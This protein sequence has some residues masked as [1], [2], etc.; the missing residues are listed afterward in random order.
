MSLHHMLRAAAQQQ[1][2]GPSDPNFKNVSLLLTGDGTNG[3]QNN[4][5]LDS[6]SNNFTITRNGNTTQGTFSPYGSLWSNYFD[7]SGDYLSRA[8]ASTTDGMYLQGT[9]YTIEA[10]IYMTSTNGLQIIYD[11]SGTNTAYFAT[12]S[13]YVD[14]GVL[15]YNVRPNTGSGFPVT[16]IVGS[17]I[18]SNTWNH[19]AFSVS[20]GSGKL[21]LNG[22]QTGSTT[23]IP[24][25]AFTPVGAAIG[26]FGNGYATGIQDFTGY[27]SNLRIVKGTA[28]YTS[29]FT[30]STTPITAVSGTSLLTCQSNRFKDNS[31]N[32]FTLTVNG[33]T[34]VQRFSP[35]NPTAPYSAATI[36]GSG[37]FDGSGDYLSVG[38]NSAFA[39]GTGDFTVE[40]WAYFNSSAGGRITNRRPGDAASGTWGF[41]ISGT[42]FAFTEV[43][44][45]EPGVAASGLPVMLSTWTHLAACRSGSTLRLFANGILVGSGTNTT[46]FANSSYPLAVGAGYESVIAGYLSQV[47]V[48]KGTAVY[49]GNFTPP[50]GPLATSGAASAASYPSTTNVNTTFA[51]SA[52][53]LLCNFTN[54]GI[55]DAAMQ[56]DLETVGNAQVSTSVKKYGTG[57][58]AFDGS[59]DYLLRP[60]VD[61]LRLGSGDFTVEAWV[62]PV[63]ISYVNAGAIAGTYAYNYASDGDRGWGLYLSSV[64]KPTI[65][66]CGS[67]GTYEQL[68]APSAISTN[69]WTHIAAT[70]SSGTLRLFVNGI[71]VASQAS[72][73]DENYA[74]CPFQVGTQYVAQYGGFGSSNTTLNG[75]IDDLR[76]TKGLARYT[77][78]FTPPTAA[79]PTY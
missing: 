12:T 61:T 24:A 44:A 30:P 36:G 63:S 21:F 38:A 69:V 34:S 15:K 64:G 52:T 60:N 4:T 68:A 47:R 45:G 32:N 27:I 10:W 3:A 65:L 26:R 5:F 55:P 17:A 22:V 58:L 51:S 71:A 33:N 40:C 37:Y 42:T 41:N 74:L 31:S 66:L 25:A 11:C 54:A 29:N 39:F 18:S 2:A 77:A 59:G 13:I 70:R 62:N 20:S 43:V 9:T 48:V 46:N 76:I 6:S 28:L 19:V 23:T 14:S 75:Y 79:L 35:F 7:G 67:T 57:S 49:T 56:N 72:T 8:F 78:N 16:E 73:K 50:T 53:S 1:A